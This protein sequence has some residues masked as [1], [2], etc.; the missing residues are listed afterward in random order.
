MH[1]LL[2]LKALVLEL[3]FSV[4]RTADKVTPWAADIA[5]HAVIQDVFTEFW[6]SLTCLL[7][8]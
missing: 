5:L 3:N 2:W 7:K 8:Y 6:R 1:S 4:V